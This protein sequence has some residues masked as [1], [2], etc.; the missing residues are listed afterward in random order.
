MTVRFFEQPDEAAQELFRYTI[1]NPDGMPEDVRSQ[2]LTMLE[3]GKSISFAVAEAAELIFARKSDLAKATVRVGAEMAMTA[4]HHNISDF[5]ADNGNR[6]KGI[7]TA[8]R[9]H[10]GDK[11]P[12]GKSWPSKDEDPDPKEIYVVQQGEV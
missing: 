5:A 6:G 10:S 12:T 4:V 8:L 11:A 3:P 9:R 7:L 1:Q 2:I